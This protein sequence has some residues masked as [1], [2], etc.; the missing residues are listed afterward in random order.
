MSKN[1]FD[2]DPERLATTDE[3]GYR[4]YLFP[5][6]VK[7]IWKRRRFAVYWFLI[8]LYLVLPWIYI[9]GKPSLML[10]I[11]KREFTFV[12]H[13]LFGV[14]PVLLFLFLISGLFFIAFLTSVYG[15]VWC[16]W[17]CPQTVFIQAIFLKIEAF[18][19]GTARQ[20]LALNEAPWSVEK[21]A[22]R[23]LKW[24]IF[25]L[26]S[27]HIAHTFVGYFVGPRELFWI[28]LQA[29]SSHPGL[30]FAVTLTTGIFL[31]DFGWFREQFC[32]IAC[33]YGRIQSVLMDEHSKVVAYDVKRG[34]PRRGSPG[35]TRENEG[36][37][38]NC[39]SCVKVC[40]TGIDIRRGTQLECIACTQCIDACDDIMEKVH[41]PKG[42]IRYATEQELQEK[43]KAKRIRP[44]IYLGFS[45]LFIS[46]FI[47]F[48]ERVTKPQMIF[49]RGTG[50]PYLMSEGDGQKWVTNKFTLKV[51]HQGEQI[52]K[53]KLQIKEQALYPQL[54]M[55]SSSES[56]ILD[57][58]EK[59]YFVFF[60]F[61]DKL[62]IEG[63]KKITVVGFDVD[64]QQEVVEKEITLV[65][66]SL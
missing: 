40:P 17:G 25:F 62:L 23:S 55:S 64:I 8:G 51:K 32:I 54:Q 30:F 52:Y 5:E 22:K 27:S 53:L 21:F 29:P 26:I 3:Q 20:R 60:K 57:K 59:K 46:A 24:L 49:L 33:P 1:R 11:A 9:D 10:N 56:L 42:L 19:E 47:F 43:P 63:S 44:Y 14:E 50:A 48:L 38:V 65:G 31:F 37:C 6:E 28:T 58:A 66:P 34:E 16:G 18:I 61:P 12:G 15:R 35:I 39:F 45:L 41:K 36:D 7:G 4:I 2:L 13:T